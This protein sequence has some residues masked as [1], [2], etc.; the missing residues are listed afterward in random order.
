MAVGNDERRYC[1]GCRSE[2]FAERN[3]KRWVAW[4][5]ERFP[6]NSTRALS[7][8]L[9]REHILARKSE[10]RNEVSVRCE[11]KPSWCWAIT[12]E[13]I[14]PNEPACLAV[15]QVEKENS[16]VQT[17]VDTFSGRIISE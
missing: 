4:K 5:G 10:K 9:E 12:I 15:G 2:R 6:A 7:D 17:V 1:D 8:I 16:F 3:R 14:Y 11:G 13:T